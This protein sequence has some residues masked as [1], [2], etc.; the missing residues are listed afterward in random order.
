MR[1]HWLIVPLALLFGGCSSCHK[2]APPGEG[3]AATLAVE[4]PVPAP[5]GLLAD[6]VVPAPD[7][8]WSKLQRG[9]GGAM[10]LFPTSTGGLLC[11]LA[12]IDPSVGPEIDGASPVF[13]AVAQDPD[14][15]A[16]AFA[17]KLVEARR[18]QTVLVDAEGARYSAKEEGGMTTLSAKGGAPLRT[19]IAIARGGYLI[20]AGKAEDLA[21][22]GPY[23]H[24]TLPT[25]PLPSS[26][27]V[28]EIPH[29][30]LVGPVKKTLLADWAAFRADKEQ[31]DAKMRQEHG[32]R[33]P[34]FADPKAILTILD[35]LVQSRVALLADLDRAKAVVEVGDA[36]VHAELT[37]VPMSG[38]GPAS[39]LVTSMHPGDARS[40]LEAPSDA[41][42]AL[43]TRGA[44][45]DRAASAHDFEEALAK[46]LGTRLG[47]EDQKKIHAAVTD[48]SKGRGDELTAWLVSGK[49]KGVIVR[50]P[51]ADPE[52]AT[53]AIHEGAALLGT[54]AFK[55]PLKTF[56][57]VDGIAF[58]S[59]DVA[60][61]GKVELATLGFAKP[62]KT[63]M[64]FAWLAKGKD[65]SLSLSDDPAALLAS[66]TTAKQK[67]GDDAHI[68]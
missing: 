7:A 26:S 19:A 62:E 52:L 45:S 2:D 63:K 4:A 57:Q 35:G 6:L 34:D 41:L 37:L 27:A 59:S 10:A 61:L 48:W 5:E 65:V 56:L 25:R 38:D 22:L 3:A 42:L 9:I 33:A 55:E 68:S 30:A 49:A 17:V 23:V 24:R 8:T 58:G 15:L 1:S 12:G 29:A 31:Q 44:E 16:Y 51:A 28:L 21:R 50:T 11:A 32:G 18:A 13:G 40:V 14:G 60:G 39:Q 46:A 53:R 20:V 36:E 67:L 66:G 64:G 43:S 47:A 54:P